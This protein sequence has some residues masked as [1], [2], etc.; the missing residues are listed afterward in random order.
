[1]TRRARTCLLL[2]MTACALTPGCLFSRNSR[3]AQT[4]PLP[5]PTPSDTPSTQPNTSPGATPSTAAAAPT[6]TS[7]ARTVR[8]RKA[9]A[10]VP[11]QPA[12]V[13]AAATNQPAVTPAPVSPPAAPAPSPAQLREILTPQQR[14]ELI[15][16]LD[17]SL[18]AARESLSKVAGRPMTRDQ[19]ESARLVSSFAAQ[20]ESARSTDLIVAAQ[21]A[22]RAELLARDL[23]NSMH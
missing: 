19:A 9:P 12:T 13:P 23:V 21:L 5:A 17:Q 1:M 10:P 8:Q 2:L 16:N 11:S 22:R 3:A 7:K 4:P 6:P 14:A 18:A 20:A 15:K